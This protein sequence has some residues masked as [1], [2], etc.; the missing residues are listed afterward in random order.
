MDYELILIRYG[1]I[2]LKAKYT[3]K[4][5]ENILIKNIRHA[6]KLSKI[7][8]NI[9]KE[10]G[11]IYLNT[12]KIKD[13]IKILEKIFG[14]VSVSPSIKSNTNIKQISDKILDLTKNKLSE[15][16]SFALRVNRVGKHNFTSQD[17]AIIIGNEIVSKTKSNVNLTSPD[18]E[19]FIDIRNES[20]YI[21]LKKIP[22]SGGMPLGTQGKVIA[23]IDEKKAILAA[24]YLIRRGCKPIF[25]LK[26]MSQNDNLISFMKRWFIDTKMYIKNTG[27]N[28]NSE[29]LK[30]IEKECCQAIITGHTIN[31]N[32]KIIYDLKEIKNIFNVPVL[33]PLIILNDDEIDKKLKEIGL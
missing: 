6:L 12:D 32:Y 26:N 4:Y 1:E 17:I 28:D 16:N 31:N 10:W 2:A 15:K 21:F 11:R 9:T 5:F 22:G 13:S 3:R 20:S 14:I 25:Y 7:N 23:I 18:F 27:K 24:W 8:N 19:I 30:I 29:I 33:C